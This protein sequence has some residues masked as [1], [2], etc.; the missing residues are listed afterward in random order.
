MRALYRIFERKNQISEVPLQT[1]IDICSNDCAFVS[2]YI[3][4]TLEALTLRSQ[5]IQRSKILEKGHPLVLKNLVVAMRA[6]IQFLMNQPA[7]TTTTELKNQYENI[8]VQLE[9]V[10]KDNRVKWPGFEQPVFAG[11]EAIEEFVSMNLLK[12]V[13]MRSVMTASPEAM[14]NTIAQSEAQIPPRRSD[15]LLGTEPRQISGVPQG[16]LNSIVASG[17]RGR[18]LTLSP[19]AAAAS[20]EPRLPVIVAVNSDSAA[21]S[22]PTTSPSASNS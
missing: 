5:G 11:N 6:H 9:V 12:P 13:A 15:T 10:F 4:E 20:S 2:R 3:R 14:R 19:A 22:S 21:D 16:L 1:Y 17:D 18:I 8:L 7:T